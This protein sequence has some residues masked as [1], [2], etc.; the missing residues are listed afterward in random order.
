LE[1]EIFKNNDKAMVDEIITFFLAGSFT[2][3]STNA[4]MLQYLALFPE[5]KSKLV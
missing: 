2:L 5:V 1:D 3:K 4:N